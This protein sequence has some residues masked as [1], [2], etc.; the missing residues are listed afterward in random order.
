MP[1]ATLTTSPS[2]H[3]TTFMSLKVAATA[4]PLPQ[5]ATINTPSPTSLQQHNT[6]A[7][8]R[9]LYTSTVSAHSSS[10]TS[11][12][13]IHSLPPHLPS[14]RL[15]PARSTPS[16]NPSQMGCPSHHPRSHLLYRTARG[17][18]ERPSDAT[19]ECVTLWRRPPRH[20]P[21]SLRPPLCPSGQPR[22]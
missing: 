11:S 3:S 21:L 13:P 15:P 9:P 19:L 8:L 20:A 7:T 17:H 22:P 16:P 14:P 1:T 10:A 4:V 18:S 2:V 12:S 6:A 5:L